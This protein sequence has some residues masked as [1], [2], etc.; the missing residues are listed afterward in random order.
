MTDESADPTPFSGN[1]TIRQLQ[2][3]DLNPTY[4]SVPIGNPLPLVLSEVGREQHHTGCGGIMG[5]KMCM[6]M[7]AHEKKTKRKTNKRTKKR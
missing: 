4:S 2:V 3:G 6:K 7:G 5:M 1:K